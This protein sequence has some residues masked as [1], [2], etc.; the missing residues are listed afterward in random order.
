MT[1]CS[2]LRTYVGVIALAVLAWP[3]YYVWMPPQVADV[4]GKCA[5][6]TGASQ[7]L[8][9][10]IAT[11][12]ADQGV[13]KLIITA[14]SAQKLENISAMLAQSFP[15]TEVLPVTSDVSKDSDIV[16][17]V[18]TA[19]KAFGPSCQTILVNNAGTET[20]QHFERAKIAAI[21]QMLDVNLRGVLHMTHAFLP[22]LTSA[23]GHVVVVASMAGKVSAPG[24]AA[25]SASKF[26]AV[27]FCLGLR[28]EMRLKGLPVSV[29]VVAPGFVEGAGMA[30]DVAAKAGAPLGDITALWGSSAPIDTARAVV[31]AVR[32]DLPEVLVNFPP[33]RPVVVVQALFPRFQ[34]WLQTVP[35]DIVQRANRWLQ[36]AA[37]A[38]T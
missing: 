33:T 13:A 12:L 24:L 22:R 3:L 37:D 29:H 18:E 8:G 9:V 26:G 2:S 17:L 11:H 28:L 10:D 4:K 16:A 21:D 36:R 7:G 30:E 38:Q 31:D 5:V 34:E 23:G 1:L 19:N 6:V 32:Y 35:L 27:G 14:R 25:Y 15:A 20:V